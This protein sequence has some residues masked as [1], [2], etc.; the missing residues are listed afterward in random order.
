MDELFVSEFMRGIANLK[1]VMMW[2][3]LLAVPLAS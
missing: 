2:L 3:E 1:G